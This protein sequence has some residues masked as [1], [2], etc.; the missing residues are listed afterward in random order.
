YKALLLR[1]FRVPVQQFVLYLGS[2]ISRMKTYLPAGQEI[3][4]Y[5]LKNLS[6]MSL[7]QSMKS[8][9]P[10]EIILAILSD[11]PSSDGKQVIRRI[12]RRLQDI[13]E[14]ATLLQRYVQQL[15]I[16]SRLRKLDKETKEIAQEMP[17]TY[18]I[19]TDAFY[20]EGQETVILNMLRKGTLSAK[21]IS[22]LTDVPLAKV[23][24]LQKK[25]GE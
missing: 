12:I 21:E 24:A 1:K 8:M 22:D 17:I 13:M 20:Q 23:E 15:I 5:D 4:G 19:K 3:T 6:E 10:E 18:D 14:D 16:L 7:D 2:G 11:Y 25:L 9:I